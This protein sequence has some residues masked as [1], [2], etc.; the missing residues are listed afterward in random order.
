MKDSPAMVSFRAFFAAINGA[1]HN[2]PFVSTI[3]IILKYKRTAKVLK[4]S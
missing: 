2:C 3:L 4:K 1:G